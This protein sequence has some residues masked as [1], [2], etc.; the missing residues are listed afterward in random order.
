MTQ[1]G[2][3]KQQEGAEHHLLPHRMPTLM[4]HS[5]STFFARGDSAAQVGCGTVTAL[6]G[7]RVQCHNGNKAQ[8]ERTGPPCSPASLRT[9]EQNSTKPTMCAHDHPAL[10]LYVCVCV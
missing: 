3:Q 10:T 9:A 6:V 5:P 1:V 8:L 4:H 2:L 7:V